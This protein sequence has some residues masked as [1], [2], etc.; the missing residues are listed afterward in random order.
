MKRLLIIPVVLLLSCESALLQPSN[1]SASALSEYEISSLQFMREEEK[2]AR[3]V[4][5]SLY[6]EYGLQQFT[7]I[8]ASEE[9]HTQAVKTLLDNYGLEDPVIEDEIGVFQNETLRQLYVDLLEQGQASES[10][11]LKVGALIEELDILDL[12]T[13]MDT[14]EEPTI[15]QVYANLTKGSRNHLRAYY[16]AIEALGISYEPV[17]L[18]SDEFY[19]IV[20]AEMERG[21]G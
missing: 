9:K 4:Y 7:N 16:S 1:T 11:A 8:A 14:I 17:Y 10:E 21:K 5:L 19:E 2:L 12:T 15:L 13:Q 18:D 3:D 20:N 6:E